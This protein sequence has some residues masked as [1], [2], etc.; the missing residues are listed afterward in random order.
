[1]EMNCLR[2]H[3]YWQSKRLYWEVV[4]EWREQEGK[5]TQENCSATWLMVLGFMVMGL[6]WGL[7]LANHS[8]SGFFLVS[9]TLLSQDGLQQGGFW[10]IGRTCGISFIPFWNASCWC[11][12]VLC[13][14][15]GLPVLKWFMQMVTMVPD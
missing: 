15:P 3:L 10:E 12:L 9:C 1:M 7:S 5:G 6:V 4:P 13:S 11:W 14:L 8:D 2:R